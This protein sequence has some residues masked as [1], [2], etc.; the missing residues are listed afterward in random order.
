MLQPP[1]AVTNWLISAIVLILLMV[2]IGGIT[3][4]TKSGLS[5]VE[6]HPV[7]GIIPPISNSNWD[8]EFTKYKSSPEFKVYNHWMKIDDFKRIFFWEYLHRL[9]GRL[10]GFWFIIPFVFFHRKKWIPKPLYFKL[11]IMFLLGALQGLAGW[12]MVKSGLADI[13]HVSHYRLALHL[14]LAFSLVAYILWAILEIVNPAKLHVSV[15]LK[16]LINIILGLSIIQIIYGAFT[17]G[18][19]AGHG[20]NT[21]PLMQGQIIPDGLL[22]LSPLLSNFVTNIMTIQ[23][24]HRTIAWILL[25][26]IFVIWW[27]IK[28]IAKTNF[29]IKSNLILL[30]SIS[31]QFILGVLT[32]I[33]SVPISLAVIHQIAACLFLAS[34]INIRYLIK[35]R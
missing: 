24:I 14:V 8:E 25:I 35:L 22:S 12:Y 1:K 13:P 20:W 11:G 3:R 23:F 6:W 27:Q 10:I 21:F 29:Q 17:A 34:L 18:L 16:Y 28:N 7:T 9:I 31:F 33:F 5:M 32:L 26:L 19:K 30:I 2:A 4:L 15:K